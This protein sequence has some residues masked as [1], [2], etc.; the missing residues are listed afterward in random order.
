MGHFPTPSQST[1][2]E[3]HHQRVWSVL[4][5]PLHAVSVA[6]TSPSGHPRTTTADLG[7]RAQ[8]ARRA[9]SAILL[10]DGILPKKGTASRSS[11]EAG[12]DRNF[13]HHPTLTHLYYTVH[14]YKIGCGGKK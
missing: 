12:F 2:F 3:P 1:R 5:H 13:S 9:E 8:T 7:Q 10:S 14:E 6:G 11:V 4:L